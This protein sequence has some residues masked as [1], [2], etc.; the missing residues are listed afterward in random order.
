MRDAMDWR[1]A[2]A[3]DKILSQIN[4]KIKIHVAIYMCQKEN[5]AKKKLPE[6]GD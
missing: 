1:P 2:W 5:E 3:T 6:I 4:F